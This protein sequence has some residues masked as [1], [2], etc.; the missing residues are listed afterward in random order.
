MTAAEIE[1]VDLTDLEF[2]PPCGITFDH[3]G[4]APTAQWAVWLKVICRHQKDDFYYLCNSHKESW[5]AAKRL[6]C[7]PGTHSATPSEIIL[8][9]ERL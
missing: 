7:F 1:V 6:F 9:L 5:L 3:L 8:R 4:G 2:A